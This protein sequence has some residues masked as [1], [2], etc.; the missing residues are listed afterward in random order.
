M[1]P[2]GRGRRGPALREGCVTETIRIG[3]LELEFLQNKIAWLFAIIARSEDLQ[4]KFR[5][6]ERLTKQTGRLSC[7]VARGDVSY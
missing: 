3:G 7:Q 2:Y 1:F 5:F 4:D 6:L